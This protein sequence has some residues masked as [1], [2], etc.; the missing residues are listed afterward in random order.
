MAFTPDGRYL[1]LG[2]PEGRIELL[3]VPGFSRARH[4]T[5]YIEGLVALPDGRRL[6]AH[7]SYHAFFFT[8]EGASL[9]QY[10]SDEINPEDYRIHDLNMKGDSRKQDL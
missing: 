5:R 6:I 4:F 7:D 10:F 2:D 8:I 1:A 3:S 9:I